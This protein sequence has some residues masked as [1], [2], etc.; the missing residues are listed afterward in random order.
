M[1]ATATPPTKFWVDFRDEPPGL[2]TEHARLLK[3]IRLGSRPAHTCSPFRQ[4]PMVHFLPAPRTLT[5]F[6][7]HGSPESILQRHRASLRRLLVKCRLS[8]GG[9]WA[10]STRARL[11][12]SW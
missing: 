5:C 11:P 3:L 7:D 12:G 6:D 1:Q 10:K 8:R 4:R 9:Y 2:D